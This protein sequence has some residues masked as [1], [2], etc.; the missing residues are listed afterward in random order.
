[1]MAEINSAASVASAAPG[2]PIANENIKIG[3]STALNTLAKALILT[4]VRVSRMPRNAENPTND[5]NDGRNANDL[6]IR[7]G[8]AYFMAGAPSVK[9]A[10]KARLGLK[11]I[12]GPP[13]MA[14]KNP[15]NNA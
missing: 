15:T 13:I 12:S 8:R 7:Y 1:M 14:M 4:G 9:T 6:I 11:Y 10:P 5:T 2:T 3:S